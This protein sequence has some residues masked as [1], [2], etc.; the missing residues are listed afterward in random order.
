LKGKI[1]NFF[2]KN[3]TLINGIKKKTQA[4]GPIIIIFLKKN[5][6]LFTSYF[7]NKET[8]ITLLIESDNALS[9][10]LQSRFR[11]PL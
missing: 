5:N 6:K 1:D 10:G 8:Y 11:P 4:S 9:T 7:F 2:N 3:S